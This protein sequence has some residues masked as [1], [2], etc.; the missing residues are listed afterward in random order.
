M[1]EKLSVIIPV[2]KV[3]PYLRQCLDSVVNQTYKNLEIILIDDGS[4]DNCGAICDEYAEKD[5]RIVVIHKK[6]GGLCA[7]RNDG[8]ER[9]TGDWLTFVDSDDWCE[10]DYYE[11]LFA[12]MGDANVDIFNA[13]GYYRD[14][15]DTRRAAHVFSDRQIYTSEEDM[16][17][18]MAKVLWGSCS[19]IGAP[20]PI[21]GVW[22]K[23]FRTEFVRSNGLRYKTSHHGSE[24]VWFDYIAFDKAKGFG[25]CSYIGYHYR[26]VASSITSRYDPNKPA[27]TYNFVKD[28]YE[29]TQGHSH[30]ELLSEAMEKRCYIDIGLAM[31]CCYIHPDNPQPHRE[32]ARQFKQMKQWEYFHKTIY[33]NDNRGLSREKRILKRLLRL[34][35]LWPVRWAYRVKNWIGISSV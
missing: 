3:E 2:Y 30:Y 11:Q 17:S 19:K 4:P 7:A 29:Y 32:V 6:N 12:A 23:L 15:G 28:V 24:D 5:K 1:N 22:D 8:I 27:D 14:D 16:V 26:R 31:N 10:L 20:R 13:G 21:S 9:A 34:P 18:L 33:S 35:W 25:C